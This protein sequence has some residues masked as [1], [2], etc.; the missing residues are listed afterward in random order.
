VLDDDERRVVGTLYVQISPLDARKVRCGAGGARI[1]AT[2]RRTRRQAAR[3]AAAGLLLARRP[4]LGQPGAGAGADRLSHGAAAGRLQGLPRRVRDDLA[5]LPARCLPRAVRPH[6]QRQDAA[7]AGAAHGRRA[8]A[9][10]RSLAHHRGSILGGDARAA[11]AHAEALRHPGL[12]GLAGFDAARPVFVESESA[13]IGSL[14]VPEALLAAMH[15][16]GQPVRVATADA[17]RIALLLDDY[18]DARSTPSR[19]AGCSTAWSNC[20]ARTRGQWQALARA[21]RWPAL[22]GA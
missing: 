2:W 20:G 4:A 22:I 11:A 14:R 7:A 13:K 19:C 18:R 3:M 17:A 10:P 12:A 15:A 16:H 6:R 1:A 21:G 8:G 9:R 5:T